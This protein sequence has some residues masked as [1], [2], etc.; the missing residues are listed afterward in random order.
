MSPTRILIW[1]TLLGAALALTGCIIGTP[2]P[3]PAP[4]TPTIQT[5]PPALTSTPFPTPTGQAGQAGQGTV[6]RFSSPPPMTIDVSA[7]YTATILTNQGSVKVELFVGQ[8]PMT[9][10]NFVFLAHEGFYN[11]IIFHR[12]IEDFMIQGGDPLG[13]GTGGP[14][15]QFQDEIDAALTFNAAGKLAMANSGGGTGTNGSQF[16]VT[17]VPTPHLDGNH[18]IFGQVTEGQSVVD[19]ISR[20]S[21]DERDRPLRSVTIEGIDIV[22]TPSS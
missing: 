8:A 1:L 11:G 19:A 4:T 16:F 6:R 13:N 15:Y 3:A 17:T 2:T 14:G 18:T 20:V 10:N 21:A 9:V 5:T 7:E 12:V 22:V